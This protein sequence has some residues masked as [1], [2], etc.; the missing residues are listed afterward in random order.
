MSNIEENDIKTI[1]SETLSQTSTPK[2]DEETKF[3]YMRLHKS[4]GMLMA[5]SIIPRIILRRNARLP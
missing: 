5:F 2:E 3:Y 1:I 4:F